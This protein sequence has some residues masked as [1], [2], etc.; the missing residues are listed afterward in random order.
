MQQKI[1][2]YVVKALLSGG[3]VVDV[4]ILIVYFI[5]YDFIIVK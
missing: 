1:V 3:G 5:Q 4:K 2:Q